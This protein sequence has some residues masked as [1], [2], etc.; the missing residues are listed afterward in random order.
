[1]RVQEVVAVTQQGDVC[2]VDTKEGAS[3]KTKRVVVAVPITSVPSI[4]FSPA[5]PAPFLAALSGAGVGVA[6]KVSLWACAAR[7][8]PQ[9]QAR[10]RPSF[11]SHVAS[12]L[13]TCCCASAPTRPCPN[14]GWTRRDPVTAPKRRVTQ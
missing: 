10:R 11:A 13:S 12:G 8:L 14:C 1:M 6:V 7:Q 3:Y 5:L 4:R 2:T 9:S